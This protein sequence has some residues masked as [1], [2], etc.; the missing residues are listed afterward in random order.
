MLF[1]SMYQAASISAS[2]R[3]PC[4][5]PSTCPCS[6]IA[7]DVQETLRNINLDGSH[8][9]LNKASTHELKDVL[10]RAGWSGNVP[11]CASVL[12]SIVGARLACRPR[13]ILRFVFRDVTGRGS[14][15]VAGSALI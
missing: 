1:V 8:S 6:G 2:I 15:S 10:V 9:K 4:V 5:P 13:F 14:K 11:E 7:G 12:T 3:L